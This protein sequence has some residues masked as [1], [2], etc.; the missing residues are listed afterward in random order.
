MIGRDVGPRRGGQKGE[1][2]GPS[3]FR[4]TP[5]A[6]QAEPVVAGLGEF[7]PGLGVLRPGEL[8]E[9]RG[10]HETAATAE[11]APLGPEVGHRPRLGARRR[12]APLQLDQLHALPAGAHHTGEVGRPHF[13]MRLEVGRGLGP[14]KDQRQFEVAELLHEGL[15]RNLLGVEVAHGSAAPDELRRASSLARRQ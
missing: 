3:P 14:G 10:G 4:R 8:E 11:A 13:L 7:P 6:R 9:V 1:A 12:K 15:V 2:V 5:E